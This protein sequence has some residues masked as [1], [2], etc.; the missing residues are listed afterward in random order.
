MLAPHKR[1]DLHYQFIDQLIIN[2]APYKIFQQ[3][4]TNIEHS[5]LNNEV[6]QSAF[7]NAFKKY[8]GAWSKA[9]LAFK[10]LQNDFLKI[11]YQQYLLSAS[12]IMNAL[13]TGM[14]IGKFNLINDN[15]FNIIDMAK[16][17]L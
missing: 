16:F 13:K 9:I 1:H 6:Y 5:H 2:E 3:Q 7:K 4:K 10:K 15:G 14:D 8:R 17:N 11:G 12:G